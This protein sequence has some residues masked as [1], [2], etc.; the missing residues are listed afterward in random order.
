MK[1]RYPMRILVHKYIC[2]GRRNDVFSPPT[3][4]TLPHLCPQ[5]GEGGVEVEFVGAIL[6]G[7]REVLREWLLIILS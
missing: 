7:N 3:K 6:T 5:S 1:R 2:E 4:T